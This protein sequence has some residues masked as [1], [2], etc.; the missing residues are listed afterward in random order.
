VQTGEEVAVK[1]VFS[2][3][4]IHLCFVVLDFEGEEWFFYLRI[5]YSSNFLAKN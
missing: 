2:K 1:L 5:Y 3:R 4:I